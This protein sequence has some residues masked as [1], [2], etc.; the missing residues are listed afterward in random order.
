MK[1]QLHFEQIPDTEAGTVVM[2]TANGTR[3]RLYRKPERIIQTNRLDEV[4]ASMREV[5]ELTTKGKYAAGFVAYEAAPAFDKALKCHKASELPM[6]WFGV[7][8]SFDEAESLKET[9]GEQE[10]TDLDT[11]QASVSERDYHDSIDAIHE[12]IGRGDTYQVNYTI[13]LRN[14]FSGSAWQLFHRLVAAQEPKYAAFLNTGDD[15]ICSASPELFFTLEGENITS[16]PMK[17]TRPRGRYCEE[18][19]QLAADLKEAEKDRAENVMIV[20]MV[21]ND[22]GHIAKV[23]SVEVPALFDVERL[24]T[25]WQLTST[26]TATTDAT[27]ADIFRA[28]FP[29]ASITGA[30]KVRTTEIIKMLEHTPRGIYTGAIGFMDPK[31]KAQFSVAIR[32]V[33]INTKSKAAEYGTGGGI[34]WDSTPEGEYE[35]ALTKAAILTT[36]QPQFQLFET[37]FWNRKDGYFLLERHLKRLE[38]SVNYFGFRFDRTKIESELKRFSTHIEN[39]SRIVKLILHRNG[40]VAIEQRAFE[41]QDPNRPWQVKMAKAQIDS[42]NRFLYHKTTFRLGY[43]RIKNEFPDCD[44]VILWN[45]RGEITE[46]TRANVVVKINDEW[47]TPPID[48]GLLAGTYRDELVDKKEITEKV[49][50]HEEWQN[51]NEKYLINSVR[52]WIPIVSK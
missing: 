20:D 21:R 24:Y 29:C 30:P 47:V 26:I 36:Q 38:N 12:L 37:M 3:W 25:V 43:D 44:D 14:R 46:S 7:Y 32:T 27:I 17:G 22:L 23:G 41:E 39:E 35:E 18:D 33:H 49:I 6:L 16:R 40:E 51:A 9:V 45:E 31:R 1:S 50:S 11:W 42:S 13:R 2:Q 4:V 5:E 8:D 19:E 34:V 28:L 52:K 48:C 10:V 15:V